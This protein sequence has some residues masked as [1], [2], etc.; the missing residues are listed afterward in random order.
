ML[1]R[2]AR[3]LLRRLRPRRSAPSR[4]R[5][6][7]RGRHLRG[8]AV[9]RSPEVESREAYKSA[10]AKFAR[11]VP[12]SSSNR[13][14]ALDTELFD[15]RRGY[16]DL[17]TYDE[18]LFVNDVERLMTEF[19]NGQYRRVLRD[20]F[21]SYQVLSH[22]ARVPQVYVLTIDGMVDFVHPGL[23]AL[24]E[25]DEVALFA[26]PTS[27]GAGVGG[28]SL[29]V[30]RGLVMLPAGAL[31]FDDYIRKRSETDSS[32][33]VL[34]LLRQSAFAASLFSGSIN[35]VR[36]LTMRDPLTRQP[37]VYGAVQRVGTSL[38][39]PVDNYSAG[40]ITFD[41]DLDTGRLGPGSPKAERRMLERHP[42]TDV[43]ITGRI[44]PN[45]AAYCE[46]AI[47]L[48]RALPYLNYI[49]WD[50]CH[51][52]DGD[53]V[54]VEAN[55][56]TDVDVFQVHRPMLLDPRAVAFFRHHGII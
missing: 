43:Q 26:K 41:I 40:G 13:T 55:K 33:M 37:F 22:Y 14:L 8:A 46:H 11:L 47:R 20:K 53:I 28:E 42:D 3:G 17:E 27:S 1:K 23:E 51:G 12:A 24:L 48:H 19:I 6:P 45:F 56:T 7:A 10:R 29:I 50:F 4:P 49:G 2:I 21:L 54:V 25:A 34:E 18:S 44:I 36:M 35:T 38:S 30:R 31:P 32:F 52:A 15:R 5:P 39:A 9:P 16:Y